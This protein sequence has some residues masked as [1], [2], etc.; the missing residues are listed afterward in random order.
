[1]VTFILKML[2]TG[3]QENT[4]LIFEIWDTLPCDTPLLG[5]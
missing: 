4:D 2:T 1:M 3:Q 5:G